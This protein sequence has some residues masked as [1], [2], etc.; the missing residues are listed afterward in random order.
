MPPFLLPTTFPLRTDRPTCCQFPAICLP[1]CHPDACVYVYTQIDYP[2]LGDVL[3]GI[4]F[5]VRCYP[6]ICRYLPQPCHYYLP[7]FLNMV[8]CALALYMYQSNCIIDYTL[9]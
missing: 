9:D 8:H 1:A 3:V 6:G 5:S 2:E 7:L 4:S